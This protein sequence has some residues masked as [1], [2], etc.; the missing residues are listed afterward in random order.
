MAKSVRL[1]DIAEKM[2]VSTVTVSNALTKDKGVGLELKKK[3]LET[4]EEMGYRFPQK[5]GRKSHNIGVLVSEIYMENF[6]SFYWSVYQELSKVATSNASFIFVEVIT[7]EKE[8]N[9]ELP[10]FITE[11][12]AEG[13]IILGELGAAYLELLNKCSEVPLQYLDFYRRDKKDRVDALISNNY[14][15]SYFLTNYLIDK[16]FKE[17]GFLGSVKA[18][19]SIIDRYFGYQRAMFEAGLEVKSEW[20][21]PDRDEMGQISFQI[22]KTLPKALVCNCDMMAAH[23][24]RA[25]RER[26]VKVPQD[27]SLVGYDDYIVPGLLDFGLTTYSVNREELAKTSI[28]TMIKRIEGDTKDCINKIIDGSLIERESVR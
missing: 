17:I 16:G 8:A 6:V 9:L 7:K 28:A 3:I 11:K 23:F 2:G 14:Y 27:I 24:V 1:S 19:C 22:P 4:A 20:I 18:T 25:L 10:L 15:G 12:K 21:I 26:G 13:I 5:E